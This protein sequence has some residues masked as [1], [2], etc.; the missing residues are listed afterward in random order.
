MLKITYENGGA[1]ESIEYQS[2][3]DFLANQRLEVPDLEDYYK[4][5]EVTLDGKPVELTDK[6]IIGLYKKFD[7]E[8]D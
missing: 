1:T 2:A 5:V 7:N 4:I 6:T 3:A 8:Q